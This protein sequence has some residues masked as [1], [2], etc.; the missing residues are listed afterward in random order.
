[1][2][3]PDV[4]ASNHTVGL[5]ATTPASMR[6]L[7]DAVAKFRLHGVPRALVQPRPGAPPPAR[8]VRLARHGI[9]Q[10]NTRVKL[11]RPIHQPA[12]AR[13]GFR[14]DRWPSLETAEGRQG[15]PSPSYRSIERVEFGVAFVRLNEH[16]R[17]P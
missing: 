7:E 2:H 1:M 13:A 10:H 17:A 6:T 4:R 12:D 8:S 15:H 16:W 14:V 11:R 3:S 5:R 9:A